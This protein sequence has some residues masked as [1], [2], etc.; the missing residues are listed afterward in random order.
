MKNK[1]TRAFKSAVCGACAGLVNGFFGGGGG[2]VLVPLLTRWLRLPEKRA[3]AT[4]VSVILPLC[5]VSA[6]VYLLRGGV[7]LSDAWPY[8][9]GGLLGGVIAGR[10][11]KKVPDKALRKIFAAALLYGGIKALFWS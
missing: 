2:L 5:A 7:L 11:M 1:K 6:F 4:C 3:L 10:T 8:L 9:A